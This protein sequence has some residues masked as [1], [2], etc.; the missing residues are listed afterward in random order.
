MKSNT[1]KMVI[2]AIFASLGTAI[3]TFGYFLGFSQFF[4]MFV[5]VMCIMATISIAGAKYG[6]FCYLTITF[7]C[8]V[9]QPAQFFY[10]LGFIIFM[11]PQPIVTYYIRKSG[12]NFLNLFVYIWYV[13][14]LFI[15]Y[16][17]SQFLFT[18]VSF[19]PF[20]E[21]VAIVAMGVGTCW[22]YGY[23]TKRCQANLDDLL[24]KISRAN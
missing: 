8:L 24:K 1:Y 12:K 16:K 9:L 18:D 13:T 17:F 4:W 2:S 10:M 11:G 3:I 14:S 5:G 19:D 23:G 21:M 22:L 6:L 15:T 20:W 7:L